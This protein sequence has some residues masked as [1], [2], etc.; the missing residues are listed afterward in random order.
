MDPV[1]S[2]VISVEDLPTA[3]NKKSQLTYK[4]SKVA[5]LLGTPFPHCTLFLDVD[6]R[7]CKNLLPLFELTRKI[8]LAYT[9]APGRAM[10]E[11][12]AVLALLQDARAPPEGFTL[13]NS[14]LLLYRLT[15]PVG[16]LFA[17]WHE[18]FQWTLKLQQRPNDQ[19][20]LWAALWI[21]L[22][23]KKPSEFAHMALPP[24]YSYRQAPTTD[25]HFSPLCECQKTMYVI[26]AYEHRC[27][28]WARQ[29]LLSMHRNLLQLFP[30]KLLPNRKR[31]RERRRAN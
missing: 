3:Y 19:I 11:D 31:K 21:T 22:A 1:F 20:T 23:Q 18:A 25:D 30:G 29:Q 8:D 28:R 2:H 6:T 4:G 26:H 24:E 7:V 14:G 5:S 17:E 9:H 16:A 27:H 15:R 10:V 12:T 13:M